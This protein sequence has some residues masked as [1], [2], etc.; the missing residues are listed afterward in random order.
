VLPGSRSLYGSTPSSIEVL[1]EGA[2]TPLPRRS[3]VLQLKLAKRAGCH[4]DQ[5]TTPA[6]RFVAS[7]A[8][9]CREAVLHLKDDPE[10]SP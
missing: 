3:R 7:R 8:A 1:A 10:R 5:N 6:G 2:A 4:E 9:K